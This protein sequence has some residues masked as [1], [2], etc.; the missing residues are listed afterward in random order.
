[1]REIR[2]LTNIKKRYGIIGVILVLFA[3][4]LGYFEYDLLNS[5][6]Q[7]LQ[8]VIEVNEINLETV[9]LKR[10]VDGDT[11]IVTNSDNEEL[12][13]RLIGVDTPESV[14]PDQSKNTKEGEK[15]SQYTKDLL[16]IGQILYLEYDKE[17]VDHYDRTLAYVWL[18]ADI[19]PTSIDNIAD[20]MLNAKLIVDGYAVAKMYK[21]NVKY[22]DIFE[23]LES[24]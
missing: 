24:Y 20:N 18:S 10:V 1:M 22:S 4:L 12:R 15:A 3:Y 9:I 5:K 2:K 7:N 6:V 13:V 17:Q 11:L 23:T 19:Q 14:N 21:P 8:S 16:T